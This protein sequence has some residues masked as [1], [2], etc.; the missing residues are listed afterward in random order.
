MV[1]ALGVQSR[2]EVGW[3]VS[4]ASRVVGPRVADAFV[5]RE[6]SKGLEPLG[7]IIR[8]QEGGEVFPELP[9]GVVVI[10]PDSGVL[11]GAVHSFDLPVRPRMAGLG[12]TM[13]DGVLAA[14]AVK[15]VQPI[16]SGWPRSARWD[17]AELHTIVGEHGGVGEDG[18]RKSELHR[19]AW[20]SWEDSNQ[21]PSDY[22]VM[23]H[24]FAE[25]ATSTR[26]PEHLMLARPRDRRVEQAGDADTVWQSTFDGGFDEA[27]CEKG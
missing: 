16:A 25:H 3:I 19:T 4:E 15:L 11:E 10:S 1:L 8:F 22:V 23:K 6:P 9:V 2:N 12:E 14:D 18:T 20:W 21:Q 24:C 13:F 7:E 26:E 17:V 5:G 27:R